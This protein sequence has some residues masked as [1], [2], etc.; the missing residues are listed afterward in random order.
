[1]FRD[2]A[3]PLRGRDSKVADA[4]ETRRRGGADRRCAL[5]RLVSRQFRR[6]PK[7]EVRSTPRVRRLVDVCL[8]THEIIGRDYVCVRVLTSCVGDPRAR[9]GISREPR[10]LADDEAP[11]V[12]GDNQQ[13]RRVTV[14]ATCRVARC[15]ALYW[16]ECLLLLKFTCPK[17]CHT[18]NRGTSRYE[19]SRR[20][21]TTPRRCENSTDVTDKLKCGQLRSPG[22]S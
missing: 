4:E 5:P 20:T 8:V 19:D 9:I 6:V 16:S 2:T 11:R 7:T 12:H 1:M 14:A 17:K 3:C 15:T 13:V 21:R 10:F 22:T 18:R